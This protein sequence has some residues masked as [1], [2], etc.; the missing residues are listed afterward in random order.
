MNSRKKRF[1]KLWQKRNENI[2]MINVEDANKIRHFK[3]LGKSLP[4]Y[5]QC[6]DYQK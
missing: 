6:F 5:I 3:F 4:I 1:W 2:A